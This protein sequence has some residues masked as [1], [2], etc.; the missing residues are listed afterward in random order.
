M[1]SFYLEGMEAYRMEGIDD[2]A[3]EERYQTIRAAMEGK[4]GA[5]PVSFAIDLLSGK[6]GFICQYDR[7]EGKDTVWSVI[8]DVGRKAVYRCEGNPSRKNY[9]EDGRFLF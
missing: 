1:N 8:Y 7:T 5:D 2:W 9:E 4:R 6:Y 3:P